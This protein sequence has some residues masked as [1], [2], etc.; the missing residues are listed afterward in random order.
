MFFLDDESRKAVQGIPDHHVPITDEGRRQAELTGHALRRE[1]GT[2]DYVYHS[3][4][5][6]TEETAEQLAA[7]KGLLEIEHHEPAG[8]EP[9]LGPA[10]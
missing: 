6:R 1:F 10:G 5:R 8:W 7:G 4:Y 9:G 3:G 2:F